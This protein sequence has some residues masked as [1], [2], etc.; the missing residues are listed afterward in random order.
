M[1]VLADGYPSEAACGH[2]GRPAVDQV[3]A[4]ADGRRIAVPGWLDEA[5]EDLLQRSRVALDVRE[6]PI[7][8]VVVLGR[9]DDAN[10]RV[11]E[12]GHGL[13][14]E[15]RPHREVGVD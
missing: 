15:L 9:L 5:E 6:R 12:V 3:C 1:D 14:E 8:D 2:D 7:A 13:V 11:S 4:R 10:L